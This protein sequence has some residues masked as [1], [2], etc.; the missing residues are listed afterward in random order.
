MREL[1]ERDAA[2]SGRDIAPAIAAP[3]ALIFDNSDYTFEQSVEFIMNLIKE[4]I[5]G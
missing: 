3:D 4:K 2:D 5:G 1:I